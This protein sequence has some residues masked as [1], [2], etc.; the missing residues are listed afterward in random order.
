MREIHATR[1]GRIIHPRV[2]RLRLCKPSRGHDEKG[3]CAGASRDAPTHE[4]TAVQS[5]YTLKNGDVATRQF[6]ISTPTFC[7]PLPT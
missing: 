1:V 3:V 7:A 4:H 2:N 5:Q 6:L